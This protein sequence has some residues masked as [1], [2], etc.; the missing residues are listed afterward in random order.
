MTYERVGPAHKKNYFSLIFSNVVVCDM[1][2]IFFWCVCNII[3]QR[4]ERY[5][6]WWWNLSSF[7]RKLSDNTH[8]SS[9]SIFQHMFTK[10]SHRY[11]ELDRCYSFDH[12]PSTFECLRKKLKDKL[13]KE[14]QV[15]KMHFRWV[16][17]LQ[18]FTHLSKK[19]KQTFL[20]IP[21]TLSITFPKN[22]FFGKKKQP[23]VY[24]ENM[25]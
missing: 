5:F 11:L 20:P 6:R 15:S 3:Y 16:Q 17:F 23:Q 12:L 13:K 10:Y 7:Q 19:K 14:S 2:W 9:S 21:I 1:F 18:S 25:L 8:L 24:I 22:I 4:I